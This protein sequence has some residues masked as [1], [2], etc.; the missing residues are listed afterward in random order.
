MNSIGKKLFLTSL[1]AAA[2]LMASV[3]PTQAIPVDHQSNDESLYVSH[4]APTL[5]R[6]ASIPVLDQT[7]MDKAAAE[8]AQIEP[9]AGNVD[10]TAA[11]LSRR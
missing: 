9:G 7:D 6:Q 11:R 4:L 8:A 1:L 2:L 10:Q 5:S 3:L